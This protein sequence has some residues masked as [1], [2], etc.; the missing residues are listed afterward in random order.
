[1]D[2]QVS[3]FISY[4]DSMKVANEKTGMLDILIAA[5]L[6]DENGKRSFKAFRKNLKDLKREGK[7][8]DKYGKDYVP[9]DY[10]HKYGVEGSKKGL[11]KIK[12]L[13]DSINLRIANK[14]LQFMKKL[15]NDPKYK[16]IKDNIETP[17]VEKWFGNYY[18]IK[19]LDEWTCKLSREEYDETEN[20]ID[21]FIIAISDA[22]YN[23]SRT[24]KDAK[25]LEPH[26]GEKV[27]DADY[28]IRIQFDL[29]IDTMDK[30]MDKY[31]LAANS[32]PATE[33]ATWSHKNRYPIFLIFT[34]T[35]G[36]LSMVIKPFTGSE[37]SHAMIAFD[38][39]LNQCWSMSER[40]KDEF[41]G[42]RYKGSDKYGL[43]HFGPKSYY[44]REII[45]KGT[46]YSVYVMYVDKATRDKM[47]NKVKYFAE[48]EKDIKFAQAGLITG[49]GLQIKK[50]DPNFKFFCSQLVAEILK[51]GDKGHKD[52]SITRP[53]DLTELEDIS[54]VN[55]GYDFYDYDPEV[56][57]KNMKLVRQQNFDNIDFEY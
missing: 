5:G 32:T 10:R 27:Y 26:S 34:Y 57:K 24:D 12:E 25:L 33:E 2:N 51:A 36:P 42:G 56:T 9:S 44:Y 55:H 21:D 3:E 15:L 22:V 45:K 20:V 37:F 41:G 23:F 39:E 38:P 1:M 50:K 40:L 14:T 52:P 43:V 8:E 4:C 13:E 53:G 6:G 28:L 35:G 29:S 18:C 11:N 17:K 54:L 48:H 7:L 47:L 16:V 46:Y 49:G 30:I 31:A 19:Q